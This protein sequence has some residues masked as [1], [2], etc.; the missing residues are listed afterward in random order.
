[1]SNKEILDTEEFFKQEFP[2]IFE[3]VYISF[4]LPEG[5]AKRV[6]ALCQE[7]QIVNPEVRACQVK[8]KFGGLRFYVDHANEAGKKLIDECES[9]CW[10]ICMY[11]GKAREVVP[12]EHNPDKLYY[13]DHEKCVEEARKNWKW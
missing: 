1:M 2:E 8:S 12:G 11:C 10:K 6:Y 7:L 4:H 5:W 3:D 9:A 13:K